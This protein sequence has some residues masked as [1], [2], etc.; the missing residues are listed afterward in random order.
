MGLELLREEGI[1]VAVMT[2][3][4]SEIVKNR[5]NKLKISETYLG[6]KR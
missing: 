3:E 4:N 6:G 2:S 5:M 1:N